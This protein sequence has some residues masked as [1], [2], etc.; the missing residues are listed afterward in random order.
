M[1]RAAAAAQPL[2]QQNESLN[3]AFRVLQQIKE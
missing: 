3:A 1:A 2:P